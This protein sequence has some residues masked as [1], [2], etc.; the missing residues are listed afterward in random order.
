M[1][2]FTPYVSHFH[3][4]LEAARWA[5]RLQT[6]N[7]TGDIGQRMRLAWK[8]SSL[9]DERALAYVNSKVGGWGVAGPHV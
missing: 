4:M 2:S 6:N 3:S 9:L 5:K 7:S 8:Q 1:D